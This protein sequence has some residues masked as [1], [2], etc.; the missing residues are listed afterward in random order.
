MRTS[1]L[2][3]LALLGGLTAC[4]EPVETIN[5]VQPHYLRK[6]D[7][8]GEWYFRQTIVEASPLTAAGGFV[9]LEG[10][11][12]KIRWVITQDYLTGYRTHEAVPGL[13]QDRTQ[14]GADYQGDP[15]LRFGITSHFDIKRGYNSGTG[16]RSN[17]VTENTSDRPWFERE[18][19]RVDWTS[20]LAYSPAEVLNLR[21]YSANTDYIR[22]TEVF[23]PGHLHID[24]DYMQVTLRGIVEAPITNCYYTHGSFDCGPG[25]V[26]LRYSFSRIGEEQAR[27][28][29][30]TYNDLIP[31]KDPDGKQL[32]TLT[33]TVPFDAST[34]IIPDGAD[35]D[36]VEFACTPEFLRFLDGVFAPGY[37]T[38]DDCSA[39]NRVD[40]EKFGFFRTERYRWDRR[41]GGGH[42]ETRE[43][44]A[45]IHDIWQNG[46]T[47][48]A[49][50]TWAPT[51]GDALKPKPVIYYLNAGFPADLEKVTGQM[52]NDWDVAFSQAAAAR[53][54][55]TV[56]A[57]RG[58]LR[59]QDPGEPWMFLAGDELKAGGMFQIRRNTCSVD[60]VEA[61]L[62]RNG[63]L[64]DVVDDAT[65]GRGI[66][67]GN[68]ERVCSGL[69]HFSRARGAEPFTWQ[70]IGDVRFNFVNWVNEVQIAGPLGYGPSSSDPETGR[71]VAGSANVYGASIDTYARSAADIVRAMNEDLDLNAV[72]SGGSY[73]DW[74][75]RPQSVADMEVNLT[76]ES[77]AALKS[78]MGSFDVEAAYGKYRLPS[79]KLDTAAMERALKARLDHPHPDD[80]IASVMNRPIDEGRQ[81]LE[82]LKADPSFRARMIHAGHLQILRPLFG[83]DPSDEPT[84]ALEEAAL[85]LSVDPRAFHAE[86]RELLSQFAEKNVYMADFI[87][88]SVIGLAL[89]LKGLD[90]DEV[91]NRLR[92]AIF[93]GVMLHELGHTVGLR[94]NF[95][96]SFDALNYQ[97]EF[98]DIAQRTEDRAER[99]RLRLPEFRYSSIM[100]YGAR[101]NSDIHGLG[102]YDLA[103]VKHVYGGITE[104][105]EDDVPVPGRLD[106]DVF[107]DGPNTIPD[108]LGGYENI[109]RRRDVPADELIPARSEGVVANTEKIMEDSLRPLADYWRDREVPYGFCSDEFNG[110]LTCR[111][112]DEGSTH[113]EVVRSAIQNYWNYYV[114]N[115]YRRGR[116]EV[117]FINGFFARQDR[118]A[119]YISYPF[120]YFFFYQNYDIGLRNDLYEAALVS[121]N[122]INQAIGTPEP[123]A[124]CL[125]P[126]RNVYVPLRKVSP[127]DAADCEV[128][129]VPVGTGR[130][131]FN[132]VTDEYNYRYDYIGSFY[133]RI[134]LLY[135][136]MDTNTSF[137]RVA[138]L[139]DRRT[140]AIGYWR[141][142]RPELLELIRNLM[143]S[144]LDGDVSDATAA[145][146]SP[147]G[148]A[149]QRVVPRVLVDR[150]AF[151]QTGAE[152]DGMPRVEAP[153]SYDLV[154]QGLVLS[155]IFN[156]SSYDEQLDFAEYLA[157]SEKGTGD[158][159]TYP[160]GWDVVEFVQPHTGVTYRAA[161]TADGDSLS[162]ELLTRANAFVADVWEPAA[163]AARA[164][165]FDADARGALEAA[166]RKL[167]AYTD[168]ISDLRLLRNAVDRA[169]D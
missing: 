80:P 73:S 145:L 50:G 51:A 132:E 15:V 115:A 128:L 13:D 102:R 154:W 127:E 162:H 161:Q 43:F 121:M 146:V 89:E 164:T 87:D 141:T 92:E 12:E 8:E 82:A 67:P 62:A 27:Y 150:A 76:E 166:D 112:W 4:T 93:R 98:W 122:F 131:E 21:V 163:A 95:E 106:L 25:E 117:G 16:E 148:P 90:P 109:S 66:L 140:F 108:L 99:N 71:I 138:N 69:T 6:A 126:D 160:D 113:S 125:D 19:F 114:F 96:G 45:N 78:R 17:V 156:T 2:L 41:L 22:E 135:Y 159:R 84:E 7:F 101:F 144:W 130:A 88:D 149:D 74:L 39:A 168:L 119:T 142:F 120:R 83:L 152:V 65:E 60:G 49:D 38:I 32:R 44:F 26:R 33:L 77:F 9:G 137:I 61:Y 111:T 28:S 136:L 118:L 55:I 52:S 1:S 100:D 20:N 3:V 11:L 165:P 23:D 79:G 91:F 64:K 85:N 123:G 97:D 133:D 81:R 24:P 35:A 86:R 129:D 29:P 158:D 59:G 94:H 57:L 75:A 104:V 10:G 116:P 40:M 63:G 151:G 46:R 68:L 30:R 53:M 48:Q 14:E 47:Q 147:D 167:E 105:F 54:G 18:Y 103:A 72:I 143:F 42:D 157:I 70:Q 169:E 36:R 155:S 58:V 34:R 37:F 56:E 134:G 5:T 139:G 107:I 110:N 153:V 124:H 31:L